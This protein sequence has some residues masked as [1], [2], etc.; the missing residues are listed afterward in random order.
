MKRELNSKL[1]EKQEKEREESKA[2]VLIAIEEL[3]NEGFEV[4]TK[5]LIERTGLS[6][7]TFSKD[8]I[9]D[10]LRQEKVCRFKNGMILKDKDSKQYLLEVEKRIREL[11][12]ENQKL[13]KDLNV[14]INKNLKLEIEIAE[15]QEQCEVL[16]GQLMVLYQKASNRGIDLEL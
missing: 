11:E 5:L 9:I 3:K 12:V 16:R 14:Q 7:S 1:R 6:R 13:K 4:S 2:K 10:V 15:K 8:H